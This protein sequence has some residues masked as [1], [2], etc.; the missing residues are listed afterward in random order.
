[1]EKMYCIATFL[2]HF[3]RKYNLPDRHHFML[4]YGM[5]LYENCNFMFTPTTELPAIASQSS[6]ESRPVP[7]SKQLT[8][9]QKRIIN[10][11]LKNNDVIAFL[12]IV[13]LAFFSLSNNHLVLNS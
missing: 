3:T 9:E 4:F 11:P 5:H 6:Q 8:H 12:S 13:S 10:H 1:M 2:L 7:A